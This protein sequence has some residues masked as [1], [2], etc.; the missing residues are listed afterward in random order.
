M[1]Q[2]VVVLI[3]MQCMIL[4]SFCTAG[5]VRHSSSSDSD[6]RS[7]NSSRSGYGG[8]GHMQDSQHAS[9]PISF[10]SCRHNG[11]VWVWSQSLGCDQR[12]C[13]SLVASGIISTCFE[14]LQNTD[15]REGIH[16]PPG[17]LRVYVVLLLLRSHKTIN[18]HWCKSQ[19]KD[20]L[21]MFHSVSAY[22][23]KD[24]QISVYMQVY[25]M[26]DLE[27]RIRGY[28]KERPFIYT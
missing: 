1:R 18:L 12:L 5:H 9:Q 27:R 24:V 2:D 23:V 6:H 15:I 25:V 8:K 26:Q 28:K 13:F 3:C 19:T 11:T 4:C 22:S 16:C 10:S 20:F 21:Q 17:D 7:A 14:L